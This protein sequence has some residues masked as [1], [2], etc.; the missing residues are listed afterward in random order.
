MSEE[1]YAAADV[2]Q[3][4]VRRD[5]APLSIAAMIVW[6]IIVAVAAIYFLAPR[7][8]SLDGLRAD[9]AARPPIAVID[10]D[11]AVLKAM[12]KDPSNAAMSDARQ[13]IDDA[14]RKLRAAGYIVLDAKDV[15]AYPPD[16]EAK[17]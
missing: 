3:F 2:Q 14:A 12:G 11:G 1:S 4:H 8:L 7:V 5:L 17:P 9:V 15:F 6:P 16:F 13:K 10:V